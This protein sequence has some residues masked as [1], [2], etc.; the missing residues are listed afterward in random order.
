MGFVD[1]AFHFNINRTFNYG[2]A[3]MNLVGTLARAAQPLPNSQIR[4][5]P[6]A[7]ET[8]SDPGCPTARLFHFV[9]LLKAFQRNSV[10]LKRILFL[11]FR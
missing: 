4:Q 5:A 8:E 9:D 1:S 10:A 3:D 7:L 2:T 6:S 11:P